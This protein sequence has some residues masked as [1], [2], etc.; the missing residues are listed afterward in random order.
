[1]TVKELLGHADIKMTLRYAHL[2]PGHK[3][4]AVEIYDDRSM[5]GYN[6]ILQ[7]LLNLKLQAC[8]C[9]KNTG[10]ADRD[11]TDDLLNAI[12]AQWISQET[13]NTLQILIWSRFMGIKLLTGYQ[14]N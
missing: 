4:K 9:L 8:K 7:C 10:G 6:L 2:A 13:V 12:S 11:R 1:V 3:V 5:S 14:A